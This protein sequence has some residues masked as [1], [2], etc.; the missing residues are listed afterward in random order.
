MLLQGAGLV[1][2]E[3]TVGGVEVHR[4]VTAGAVVQALEVCRQGRAE[5]RGAVQHPGERRVREAA[6]FP[7]A[8]AHGA[9]VAG[10]PALAQAGAGA[11]GAVHQGGRKFLAALIDS[12]RVG[13]A[14]DVA[15][16]GGVVE[17]VAGAGQ[18]VEGEEGGF[19]GDAEGA[20]R[21]PAAEK[22]DGGVERLHPLAKGLLQ[23]R[24]AT[25][26][27]VNGHG[28]GDVLQP[29]AR[30][31]PHGTEQAGNAAGGVGAAAEAEQEELITGLVVEADEAVSLVHEVVEPLADATLKHAPETLG[32]GAHAII[33]VGHLRQR[34]RTRLIH[35]QQALQQPANVGDVPHAQV[36]PGAVAADDDPFVAHSDARAGY[37]RLTCPART[38]FTYWENVFRAI[39]TPALPRHPMPERGLAA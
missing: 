23:R 21:I 26:G 28:L 18:P 32:I 24:L 12:H 13:R 2:V 20:H 3:Q 10:E 38:G 25:A 15:A 30:H 36:V 19:V 5:R 14:A 27:A 9:V 22:I 35:R 39:D 1:G 6:L 7:G 29:R 34:H 37:E 17:L 16:E 8:A 33:V 4:V 11:R 31:H